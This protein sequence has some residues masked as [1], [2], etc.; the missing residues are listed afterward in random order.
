MAKKRNFGKSE[1][2]AQLVNPLGN[3]GMNCHYT[4]GFSQFQFR[5]S[6][7]KKDAPF[8]IKPKYV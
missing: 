7:K 8:Q 1:V 2:Q 6:T 5:V 4:E 3:L